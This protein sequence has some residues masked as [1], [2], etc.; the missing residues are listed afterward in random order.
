M[1]AG[2]AALGA[3]LLLDDRRPWLTARTVL[4]SVGLLLA[5]AV[6]AAP[7]GSRDIWSY[8]MYGRIVSEH[9]DNPYRFVP[10]DFAHDPMLPRVDPRWGKEPS[11]YG[12]A[13]VAGAAGLTLVG[14]ESALV[15][16][17]LFQLMA[18]GL[19]MLCVVLVGRATREPAAMAWL[20]LN[21]LVALFIANPGHNDLL[22]GAPVLIAVL[23]AAR[24]PVVAGLLLGFATLVKFVALVAMAALAMSV[25][26][27]TGRRAFCLLVGACGAVALAGSAV[28]GGM[29]A[30]RPLMLASAWHSSESLATGILKL[31]AR[32]D[33]P[34]ICEI[35]AAAA[36][37]ARLLRRPP[38]AAWL[39]TAAL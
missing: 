9:G 24:R 15:D 16:R 22:V 2:Y 38:S 25:W 18:S 35:A 7:Q 6:V 34:L 13:F 12:P 21:P 5:V 32:V 39:V 33:A 36:I 29:V 14:D 8:V 26:R 4:V 23:V 31:S 27:S 1:I 20:G 30:V 37:A 17:L 3:L 28:A 10:D 11:M 19:V